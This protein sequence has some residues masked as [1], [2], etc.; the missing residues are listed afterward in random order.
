MTERPLCEVCGKTRCMC[1]TPEPVWWAI[2]K[3][4]GWV[5]VAL[6]IFALASW[7][8]NGWMP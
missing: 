1:P 2:K 7:L 3:N 8:T 6:A 4:W 5:V